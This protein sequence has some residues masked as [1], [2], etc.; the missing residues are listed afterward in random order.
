MRGVVLLR[1]ESFVL[2]CLWARGGV[3]AVAPARGVAPYWSSVSGGGWFDGDVESDGLELGHDSALTGSAA[4]SPVEVVAAEVVIG[5]AVGEQMPGND[6]DGVPDRDCCSLGSP[7]SSDLGVLGGEVG[8]LGS[9][10]GLSCFDQRLAQ[11]LG[12]VRGATRFAFAGRL[13]V[14]GVSPCTSKNAH[15]STITS[16]TT[17]L[18]FEAGPEGGS[19][20]ETEIRARSNKTERPSPTGSS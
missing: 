10:G 17:S 5:F 19:Y 11:P 20:E 13:V 6:E 14:G 15:R 3:G 18:W 4:A 1:C 12:A 8:V 9:P 2:R 16:I 7:S